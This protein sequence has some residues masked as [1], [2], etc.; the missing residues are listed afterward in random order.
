MKSLL[1]TIGA[2]FAIAVSGKAAVD[3]NIV[4]DNTWSSNYYGWVQFSD[5]GGQTFQQRYIEGP[6]HSNCLMSFDKSGVYWVR[7]QI[8]EAI[9]IKGKWHHALRWMGQWE[10]F[11]YNLDQPELNGTVTLKRTTD[12]L[13]N[14]LLHFSSIDDDE[15]IVVEQMDSWWKIHSFWRNPD[16]ALFDPVLRP[17][18]LNT[19]Y[20]LKVFRA[21]K[22]N[23][24]ITKNW[25]INFN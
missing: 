9:F 8:N 19:G 22:C 17:P 3:Q 7:L 16:P 21:T 6:E 11:Y 18:A 12:P 14:A 13:H 10:S 2:I 15:Q 5:D 4:W 1:L 23:A 25:F 20:G 24:F